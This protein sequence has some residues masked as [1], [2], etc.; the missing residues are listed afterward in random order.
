MKMKLKF[1][2]KV[3]EGNSMEV[4]RLKGIVHRILNNSCLDSNCLDRKF[5]TEEQIK[6]ILGE[7][8]QSDN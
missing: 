4:Y 2:I 3:S 6:E 7:T 8:V 5:Y 1:Y